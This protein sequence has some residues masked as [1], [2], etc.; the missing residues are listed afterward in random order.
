MKAF[1]SRKSQEQLTS[2]M[3]AEIDRLGLER[4]WFQWIVD[5]DGLEFGQFAL[6]QTTKRSHLFDK[7][8]P[9]LT[10]FATAKRRQAPLPDRNSI[11][12]TNA[13]TRRII[14][15]KIRDAERVPCRGNFTA[16]FFTAP[17]H[18]LPFVISEWPSTYR[19]PVFLTSDELTEWRY[20]YNAEETDQESWWYV[21][22][23]WDAQLNPSSDSFWLRDMALPQI[24]G[25]T[26]VLVVWGLCWGS[27]AGGHHAELWQIDDGGKEVFLRDVGDLTY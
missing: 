15:P 1:S 17:L 19:H 25:T 12:V 26:P 11:D 5:Q 8:Y 4:S 27:L 14:E 22:Q 9:R 6:S 2:E 24:D 23:D 7:W 21:F 18:I 3:Y 20:I 13:A 16:A 10:E